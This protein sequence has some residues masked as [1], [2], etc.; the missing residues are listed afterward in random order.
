[1]TTPLP[2][3][4]AELDWLEDALAKGASIQ[5]LAQWQHERFENPRSALGIKR[6]V[7][8][9]GLRPGHVTKGE[10]E[11]H[12]LATW[13]ELKS[14][15]AVW[16]E[17][18]DH[19]GRRLAMRWLVRAEAAYLFGYEPGDGITSGEYRTVPC[20]YLNEEYPSWTPWSN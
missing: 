10:Y 4:P 6:I 20:I 8:K 17:G 16:R 19:R 1:M 7:S 18:Y 5:Q 15:S 13:N 11:A 2:I 12:N 3:T 14:E 9:Y